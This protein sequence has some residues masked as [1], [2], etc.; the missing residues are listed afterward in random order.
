[1][2][3]SRLASIARHLCAR[4][5]PPAPTAAAG[6]GPPGLRICVGKLQQETNDLNP[7]PTTIQDFENQGFY[8][9]DSVLT[10]AR[11]GMIDGFLTTVEAWCDDACDCC[12]CVHAPWR[13][14][15][16][17]GDRQQCHCSPTDPSC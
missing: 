11:E 2:D 3:N 13:S 16:S 12:C 8:H 4:R 9:G 15:P 17:P 7:I 14:C 1:M 10:D 5:V 6:T